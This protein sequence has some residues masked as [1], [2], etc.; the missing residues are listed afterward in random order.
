MAIIYYII[1]WTKNN[2]KLKDYIQREKEKI[3]ENWSKYKGRSTYDALKEEFTTVD[4][5]YKPSRANCDEWKLADQLVGPYNDTDT[6]EYAHLDRDIYAKSNGA[7]I[8][9]QQVAKEKLAR[10]NTVINT[11]MPGFRAKV[12]GLM[13]DENKKIFMAPS[14]YIKINTG[15]QTLNSVLTKYLEDPFILN[16]ITPE[17][18]ADILDKYPTDAWINIYGKLQLIKFEFND[19]VNNKITESN[20]NRY[21]NTY[22]QIANAPYPDPVKGYS[23]YPSDRMRLNDEAVRRN[24]IQRELDKKVLTQQEYNDKWSWVDKIGD[25]T[26]LPAGFDINSKPDT[27]LDAQTRTVMDIMT[28]YDPSQFGCQRI[29]QEC[30]TRTAPGFALDAYNYEKYDAYLDSLA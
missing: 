13:T 28:D 30:G 29:Y 20:P 7:N 22:L 5:R 23:Y 11:E 16:I 9:P 12:A 10:I 19:M 15:T 1:V 14:N 26:A 6:N 4:T 18:R 21:S 24:I 27:I 2:Q 8:N 3:R 25:P 17:N